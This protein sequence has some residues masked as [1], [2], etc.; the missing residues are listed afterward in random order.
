MLEVDISEVFANVFFL[1]FV[2]VHHTI[3]VV[4]IQNTAV[5]KANKEYK[6]K[7]KEDDNFEYIEL[8]DADAWS[9]T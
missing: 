3:L 6:K 7:M 9:H 1:T 4:F 8:V 5:P 2:H